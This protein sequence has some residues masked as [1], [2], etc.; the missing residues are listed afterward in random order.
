MNTDERQGVA[1]RLADTL[2]SSILK[3]RLRPGEAL[4]SERDLAERY[5]INRSTVRE[6]VRRLEAW[7][8]VQVRHGGA[9]KVRDFLLSAGIDLLPHLVEASGTVDPEVLR[10]LHE[11]RAVLLGWSAEEAA[12]KADG[13]SMQRLD[14]LVRR[15]AEARPAELQEL[16]Y[17]FFQLL[18]A[19]SGNR[20]MALFGNVV[21]D[22]YLAGRERF[23]DM[24]APG[25]FDLAHHRRAV[26]AIRARDAAA[27]GEAMRAHARTAMSA[28]AGASGVRP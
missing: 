28:V 3:G 20:V 27:A 2:R 18:V 13:A 15:M 8:L 1:D 10:D 21:R 17:D 24:Y 19:I 23:A 9:T 6:A 7:G 11:V 25:V 5:A 14:E 12:N 16:D 4:P 22:V 26:A